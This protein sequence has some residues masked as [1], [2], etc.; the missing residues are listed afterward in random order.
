M[1]YKFEKYGNTK[2]VQ[3]KKVRQ[4]VDESLK[5]TTNESKGENREITKRASY[6]R[7]D[8]IRV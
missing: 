6:R 2:D 1:N 4:G 7:G 5:L 3:C 8:R